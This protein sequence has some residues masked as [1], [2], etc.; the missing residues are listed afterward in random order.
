MLIYERI[1][2]ITGKLTKF[3]LL[4]TR[5]LEVSVNG[6]SPYICFQLSKCLPITC[7]TNPLKN[8][9]IQEYFLFRGKKKGFQCMSA[10][11]EMLFEFM[12]SLISV[13][14]LI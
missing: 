3:I 14:S 13:V 9:T 12:V 7:V 11:F 4:F 1:H 10:L 2:N 6:F 5:K 8:K